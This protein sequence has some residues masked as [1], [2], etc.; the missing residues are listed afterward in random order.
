M[1]Q[2]QNNSSLS[3]CVLPLRI[4]SLLF[5]HAE[6]Q[7]AEAHVTMYES[8]RARNSS[9]LTRRVTLDCK[10]GI[11]RKRPPVENF[12]GGGRLGT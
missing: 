2:D 5:A 11:E 4:Y 1:E 3:V 12:S 6:P 7:A 8:W 10:R 9:L